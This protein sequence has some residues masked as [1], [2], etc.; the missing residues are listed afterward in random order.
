MPMTHLRRT[1]VISPLVRGTLNFLFTR[2][3]LTPPTHTYFLSLELLKVRHPCRKARIYVTFIILSRSSMRLLV[4]SPPKSRTSASSCTHGAPPE[5]T[6][7]G[8]E[9]ARQV[10][11][12]LLSRNQRAM[13]SSQ[14]VW[15]HPNTL[16]GE[17]SQTGQNAT[18]LDLVSSHLGATSVS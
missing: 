16:L 7:S 17:V 4:S 15:P 18:K 13:Q 9:G 14:N 11:H 10:G 1:R 8:A 6:A 12:V 2:P 5:A 3:A